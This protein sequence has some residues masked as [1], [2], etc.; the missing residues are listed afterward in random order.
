MQKSIHHR[1]STQHLRII[2]LG[3]VVRGPLG[4]MVWSNLQFL[5]GIRKLGHDVYFVEDSDDYPSCYD[6]SRHVTDTD[7]SYGLD[8]AGRIFSRIGMGERWA[9]YDAH[10]AS[11]LGPCAGKIIEICHDADVVLNLCGVN[12]LR[13]WLMNAPV[14]VFI[15]EDP[16][17]TQISHNVNSDKRHRALQHNAF[18]SFAE[19]IGQAQCSVPTDGLPWRPMRQPLV[20]DSI[21]PS[22]GK[23]NGRFTTVMQWDS[24]PSREFKGVK[25][26]MKSDSFS[27]FIDLPS[28]T[29][30]LFELAV[31][32]PTAPLNLLR[33]K[34]W[35]PLDPLTPT[36]DPWLYQAYIEQSKAEFSIAKEAYVA[37]G[38]GWFSERS[39]TYLATGRPVVVQETGFS[40]W[41]EAGTGVV[42]FRNPEEAIA[43]L[44]DVNSRY[45]VH[46]CAAREVAEEYFDSSKILPKLLDEAISS[47]RHIESHDGGA[48]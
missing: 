6:P 25:Y 43:A 4:G 32:G 21:L 33:E 8:F 16:A 13:P 29:G 45:S 41:L 18:F 47:S 3:Y 1:I 17:F 23:P 30:S 5:M 26:G 24:Y 39:V 11:W 14:R 27:P 36:R 34:G 12:P 48:I 35:H 40:D 42:S 9:Y 7:P 31:G 10:T 19:N 46:C 28:K 44:E 22:P 15:D 20:L 37:T 38:S 2:V